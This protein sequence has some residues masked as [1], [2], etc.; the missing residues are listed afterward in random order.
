[1]DIHVKLCSPLIVV[2]VL[3][4]LII[5]IGSN[6]I[7]KELSDMEMSGPKSPDGHVWVVSYFS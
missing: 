7:Y 6:I 3:L 4:L 1:M 2:L 5:V